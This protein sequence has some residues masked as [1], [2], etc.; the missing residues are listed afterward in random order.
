MREEALLGI[1][2]A[3]EGLRALAAHTNVDTSHSFSFA[4][5]T[6]YVPTV[7]LGSR[8]VVG[9]LGRLAIP[10]EKCLLNTIPVHDFI[11][12]HASSS[13]ALQT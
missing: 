5:C 4:R 7:T 9:Q 11:G 3:E 2:L 13:K 12:L 10:I 8:L 6:E 1:K